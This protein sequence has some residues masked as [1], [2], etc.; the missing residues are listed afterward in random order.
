MIQHL[1][2]NC[3]DLVSAS[4]A[5]LCGSGPNYSMQPHN[6]ANSAV[7]FVFYFQAKDGGDVVFHDPRMN[8]NRGYQTEFQEAFALKDTK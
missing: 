5:W 2:Q 4:R 1:G 6:H 8:A 7:S 3:F